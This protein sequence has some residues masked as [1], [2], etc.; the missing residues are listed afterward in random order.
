MAAEDLVP[1]R[2]VVE[3]DDDVA[4][5]HKPP[6]DVLVLADLRRLVVG[7]AVDVD[8]SVVLAIV[9]V[10]PSRTRLDQKLNVARRAK[11]ELVHEVEPPH[12]KLAVAAFA[13]RGHPF[14]PRPGAASGTA[15]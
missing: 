11:H 13:Q 7:R 3:A 10:G 14:G 6:G 1:V 15:L 5:L 9:E 12:L 8:R 4:H 2:S